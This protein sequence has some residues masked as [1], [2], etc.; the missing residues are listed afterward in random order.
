MTTRYILSNTYYIYQGTLNAM[1]CPRGTF[2]DQE[3]GAELADCYP[4]TPGQYCNQTG[5]EE[6]SGKKFCCFFP[7]RYLR[8]DHCAAIKTSFI[9][10]SQ[11]LCTSEKNFRRNLTVSFF[12]TGYCAERYYCPDYA[13]IDSPQPSAFLCPAGFY[14][15]AATANPEACPPGKPFRLNNIQRTPLFYS[16]QG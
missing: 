2:R 4:C 10:Y 3:G 15:P 1:Q 14:C 7:L 16:Y 12:L 8:E 5:L 6:P 11:F 9:H 13:E